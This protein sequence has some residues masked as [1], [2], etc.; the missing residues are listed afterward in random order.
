MRKLIINNCGRRSL[1]QNKYINDVGEINPNMEDRKNNKLNIE[2]LPKGVS[3]PKFQ[4]RESGVVHTPYS[5]EVAFYSCIK[6]G[7]LQ[8]LKDCMEKFMFES[9]VVGRMSNDNL[10]QSKYMAVSCITLATRYAV[11]GGLMESEAYNL[12]D[13]YIQSVDN[14]DDTDDIL[15]FLIEKA[16]ELTTLVKEHKDRLEYPPY[17]RKAIKTIDAHLHDKLVCEDIAKECGV[18]VDYLT[19]QFK[20]YVGVSVKRY[21]LS[22][23]LQASKELLLD[24]VPYK[25]VAYYFGFCSQ[26]HYISVFEKEYGMTPKQFV[27][28]NA[29]KINSSD[30]NA[31]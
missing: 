17:I 5:R 2:V 13:K 6:N 19:K 8:G 21:V 23:K 9:L 22:Q 24:D 10:R 15:Y 18:C 26:T 30:K 29:E 12:S 16:G 7:D 1:I 11:E 3:A 14:M 31:K 28:A 25:D 4:Q 27:V 20:A